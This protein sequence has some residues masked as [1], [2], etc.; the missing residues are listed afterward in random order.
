MGC[1]CVELLA[2]RCYNI[3]NNG[4]EPTERD[5]EPFIITLFGHRDLYAHRKVEKRLTEILSDLIRKK[6]YIEIYIGRNGEFDIFAASVVKRVIK[7]YSYGNVG[8]TL[9]LPYPD[10]DMEYYDDYYDSVMIP[11]CIGRIHP[12]G[13]I[14]KRNRWMVEE[15]N[16]FI[17]YIEHEG[18][19]ATAM[20]YAQRLGKDVIN[21]AEDIEER[22]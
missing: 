1:N 14:T 13:A 9:V 7:E 4:N 18:G 3:N 21:M 15:C 16:L 5:M 2:D 17:G 20:K 11:E 12:K 8:M 10:K 6:E 22:D 19:A